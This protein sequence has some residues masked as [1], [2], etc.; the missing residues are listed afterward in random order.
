MKKAERVTSVKNSLTGSELRRRLPEIWEIENDDIREKTAR[1]Y[2]RACPD[3]FWER[4]TSSSGNY[5]PKDERGDYGNWLHTKRVYIQFCN[6]ARVDVEMGLLSEYEFACGQSAALLH[7][8]MKYGWPSSNNEH[9]VEDHD[10]IASE[11]AQHIGDLP[12]EVYLTIHAHMSK[13]GGGKNPETRLEWL[14]CRADKAVSP[15]WSTIGVIEP[16]DELT[17]GLNVVGY[18]SSG[19]EL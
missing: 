17:E 4:P 12:P 6:L 15:D 7:D 2:L 5:H 8:M 16:A 19:N 10:V 3:Y 18:D 9:T 13:W 1:C 11:V 14:L